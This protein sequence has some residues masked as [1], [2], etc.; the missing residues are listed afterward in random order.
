MKLRPVSA[1]LS[2]VLTLLFLF[3]SCGRAPLFLADIEAQ[4]PLAF[5]EISPPTVGLLNPDAEMRGVWIATVGNINYPSKKGLSEKELKKE[6]EDIVGKCLEL[7]LNAI[8]F[9][10][11]PAADA[12]YHSEL[13]P[14]SE[15]LSGKQGKAADGDFDPLDYLIKIA[16]NEKINVHA[17]V[18]PLR[19]TYGSAKYPKTDISSLAE[20]HIA[21]KNPDWVLPY[22]DGKLYFDAGN[23]A[24]REYIADGV[25]EIVEDYAVDGVVFDD[26]FYPYPVSG[27][28]F[29]DSASFALYG[30]G[31]LGDWRR[32][33]INSLVKGCYDAV[34]S[35]NSECLFGISPF[36]IWQNDD[37]NNG[38]SAT[39]GLEAYE[40]LY[41]DA[42]AW[43]RGGYV[44]YISPQ[45]YW[46]FGTK[47]APYGELSDW[48]NASLDGTGVKLIISHAAYMYDEWESP[49]GELKEQIEYSR[50]ALSYRGSIL[51]GFAAIENNS[52]GI[53]GEI[54]S[55]FSYEIIYSDS[56]TNYKKLA[57]NGIEDGMETSLSLIAVTGESDPTVALSYLGEGVNRDKDGSFE[58]H[59]ALSI[60]ENEITFIYGEQKFS[61]TVIRTE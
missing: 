53:C 23:P 43:A 21:R 8:F 20:G 7:G 34:K 57:V 41:C 48:W 22:A 14:T 6:L 28:S 11:R 5:E 18:N 2:F 12:L 1:V 29:D 30:K 47:A 54:S 60:G 58:L 49:S 46:R 56:V 32:E 38:G 27:A 17:W 33:N 37:G 55:V 39:S 35:V 13:F 50:G 9:Q 61:F 26:Y 4:S 45:L 16:H 40:S 24:V 36:G 10:V 15:Y 31:E 19:V 44:D 42:L 25:R 51:Y 59:I 3:S 52:S